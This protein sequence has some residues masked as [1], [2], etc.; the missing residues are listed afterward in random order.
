M[1]SGRKRRASGRRS[2]K[3]I[4]QKQC[5]CSSA[6]REGRGP[7][8]A[9]SAESPSSPRRDPA[10]KRNAAV[11]SPGRLLGTLLQ[12]GQRRLSFNPLGLQ[13][14]QAGQPEPQS[15]GACCQKGVE[16]EGSNRAFS[17]GDANRDSSFLQTRDV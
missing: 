17:V 16:V 7:P 9:P 3:R 5:Q 12:F 15:C 13:R 10:W 6:P 1:V 2:A 11:P 8:N 4:D 14:G